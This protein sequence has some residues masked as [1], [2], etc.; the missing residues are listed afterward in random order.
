M[1][2][3]CGLY[4]SDEHILAA[5]KGRERAPL[6]RAWTQLHDLQ[7]ADDLAAI[8]HGG[9]LYRFDDNVS[10][11]MQAAK[12]LYTQTFP[13]AKTLHPFKTMA[14]MAQA[15]EL[16]RPLFSEAELMYWQ[17]EFE[18]HL[19]RL[20][21]GVGYHEAMWCNTLHL[22]AGIVLEK[23][24]WVENSTESFR[25]VV[26]EDIHPDGYIRG[27]VEVPDGQS[28]FR[29]LVSTQALVLMAEAAKHIGVDLWGYEQR[30]VSVV[31]AAAYPLYYYYYPEKWRWDQDVDPED[32]KRIFRE[33]GGF[34]EI[35]QRQR[36]LHDIEM[37]LNE[38]R[39]LFDVNGGGLTTLSHGSAAKRGLFG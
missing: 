22:I 27:A 2:T 23:P 36:P 17:T 33:Q 32:T 31:T 39:P 3:H 25:R 24:E 30:G 38:W 29:H 35:V 37:L 5:R 1:Y 16:V 21:E 13:T 7:P 9:F 15:C 18:L 4:F 14:A 8:L 34:L 19:K 10:A 6:K 26:R 28:F 11:G 12:L 20:G